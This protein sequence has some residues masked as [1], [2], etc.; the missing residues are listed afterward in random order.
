MVSNNSINNTVQ[1]NDFSVN[2]SG[3]GTACKSSVNHSD[4]TNTSSNAILE[5]LSGG[6]S[7]GDPFVHLQVSGTT[8]VSMGLDNTDS[9]KW[10][11]TTGGSPSAG[12]ERITVQTTGEVNVREKLRVGEETPSLGADSTADLCVSKTTAGAGVIAN[13]RNVDNTNTASHAYVSIAVGGD[14][15]GDPF[16]Q[17]NAGTP[18]F[19]VGIDNSDSNK[20]KIGYVASGGADPSTLTSYMT[21]TTAGEII[22]PLQPAF[23]AYLSST[24]TNKTGN[25]TPYTVIF[26]TELFDQNSDYNNATGIFTAPV[27]GRYKFD[28]QVHLT[29]CTIADQIAVTIVT[30]SRTYWRNLIRAASARDLN[31]NISLLV[32][33]TAADTAYIQVYGLGEAGDTDDV[34][35][36]AT[37]NYTFFSVFLAC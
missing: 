24:Q 31:I 3:A 19:G 27:T 29:G 8:E 23:S 35:G 22:K 32:P 36:S 6:A 1:N 28:A 15:G 12:S 14:S 34:Y 5:A 9:D 25:G 2:R 21:F 16:V 7:G 26:D 11:Y 18:S 4:N 37:N 30:T 10:K 17:F 13:V 20:F 33:M